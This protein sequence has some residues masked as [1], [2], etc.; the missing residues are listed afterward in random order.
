MLQAH[1]L[2]KTYNTKKGISCPAVI[3]V[4]LEFGK[5]G[6]VFILGKS[7]SGKSTLLNLLSGLDKPDSGEI[8]VDGHS[9]KD[10]TEKDYDN[11][12]NSCIGFIFQEIN[13]IESMTVKDNLA[14]ALELQ[15]K[16]SKAEDIEKALHAVGLDGVEG[17][18]PDELSGGQKQ[19]VAIARALVKT[20]HIIFADEPT[21][22]LDSDTGKD[23]IELLKA[24]SREKLIIVVTHDRELA[25][26]D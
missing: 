24:L 6:M 23:I 20:P 21:G 25:V 16:I 7:G 12:R 8:I 4:S 18:M 11:Y 19:R 15:N 3:D 14:V 5:T 10:F 13:L 17:R 22:N 2:S 9:L 1:H 26:T